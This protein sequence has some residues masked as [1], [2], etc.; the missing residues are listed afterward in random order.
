MDE[1]LRIFVGVAMR[2]AL[3]GEE[4]GISP[5]RLA[6]GAPGDGERPARQLLAGVPLA[7]AEVQEAALAVFV[8]QLADQLGREAALG[9][10]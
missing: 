3:V 6:V 5:A 10:A 1:A 2:L 7:L 4:R 8:A 9:G